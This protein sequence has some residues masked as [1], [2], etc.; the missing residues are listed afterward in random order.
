MSFYF[1]IAISFCRNIVCKN[2][3]CDVG[4][5]VTKSLLSE[6]SFSLLILRS[7][8]ASPHH[9]SFHLRPEKCDKKNLESNFRNQQNQNQIFRIKVQ[10]N[11]KLKPVDIV[12]TEM[13]L[14]RWRQSNRIFIAWHLIGSAGRNIVKIDSRTRSFC[15]CQTAYLIRARK[16]NP[17]CV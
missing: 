17:N 8:S 13:K 4:L 16:L 14:V 2:I 12:E 6:I 11:V 7:H 15:L 9:F 5:K 3:V 10:Q 1:L